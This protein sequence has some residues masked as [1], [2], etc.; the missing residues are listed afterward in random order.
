MANSG[1]YPPDGATDVGL[2]RILLQDTDATNIDPEAGTADY[3]MFS[4]ADLAGFFLAGGD[5][6]LRGVG[7]AYL[8][9]A[10]QAAL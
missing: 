5:S 4:D 2:I 3:E 6:P 7:F 10:G 8:S 9:L 1:V